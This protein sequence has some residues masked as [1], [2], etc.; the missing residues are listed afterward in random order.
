MLRVNQL[1]GFGARRRPSLKILSLGNGI[2]GNG[3][4][5]FELG[6][7]V[8]APEASDRFIVAVVIAYDNATNYTLN[9]VS[10][11][12][13]SGT[14][15][16]QSNSGTTRTKAAIIGAL[17]PTDSGGNSIN[18]TFSEA[19]NGSNAYAR[20]FAVYGLKSFTPAGITTNFS[21]SASSLSLTLGGTNL[22]G[23]GFLLGGFSLWSSGGVASSVPVTGTLAGG[24]TGASNPA[25]GSN[26][27]RAW[28]VREN[29]I[30]IADPTAIVTRSNGAG[31]ISG[32]L[33]CFA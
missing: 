7:Y 2:N 15:F 22:A 14:I 19:L 1:V 28:G 3:N 11:G 13:S 27:Q 6:S 26:Y 30:P 16:G 33:A 21:T 10:F 29:L 18:L 25:D 17:R 4:S 12:G 9:A 20:I 5:S 31:H 24:T 32:A 23:P 8:D